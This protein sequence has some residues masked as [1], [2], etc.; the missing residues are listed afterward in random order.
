MLLP[1]LSENWSSRVILQGMSSPA[2]VKGIG[3]NVSHAFPLKQ[4]CGPGLHCVSRHSWGS[5][6]ATWWDGKKHDLITHKLLPSS[7]FSRYCSCM[8]QA[9]LCCF[10][11]QRFIMFS[12]MGTVWLYHQL[13][14][15]NWAF[16][17][18]VMY[19]EQWEN[20]R[21]RCSRRNLQLQ[22]VF[23]LFS[24]YSLPKSQ[25]VP[26]LTRSPLRMHKMY[27]FIPWMG[28]RAPLF[29]LFPIFPNFPPQHLLLGNFWF[30]FCFLIL[31]FSLL[32]M[33]INLSWVVKSS[34]LKYGSWKKLP[35]LKPCVTNLGWNKELAPEYVSYLTNNTV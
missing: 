31:L 27:A 11:H 16:C 22:H 25:K 2:V 10:L 19:Q 33:M 5:G 34:S 7:L 14:G 35:V 20:I 15:D 6:F 1:I 21:C 4:L 3:M 18:P 8:Y 29:L 23:A 32:Q 17:L 26:F 9:L 13:N 28:N 12:S 30:R 24:T